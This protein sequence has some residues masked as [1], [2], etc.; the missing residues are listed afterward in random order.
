MSLRCAPPPAPR[1]SVDVDKLDYLKR[2]AFMCGV[3][4]GGDFDSLLKKKYIKVRGAEVG[5]HARVCS[6]C[7]HTHTHTHT[8]AHWFCALLTLCPSKH[9]RTRMN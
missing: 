8:R 3:R 4:V 9:A 5:L 6:A 7:T 2:D 1:I